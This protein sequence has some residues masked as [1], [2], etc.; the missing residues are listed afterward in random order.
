M[1]PL[2][3]L[4]QLLS[5]FSQDLESAITGGGEG[6]LSVKQLRLFTVSELKLWFAYGVTAT[7]H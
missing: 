6:T 1:R 7:E 3:G 4:K 2:M 5:T